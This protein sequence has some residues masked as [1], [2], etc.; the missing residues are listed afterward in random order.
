MTVD[1]VVEGNANTPLGAGAADDK[2]A[3]GAGAGA[4]AG[5]GAGSGAKDWRESFTD[6][7]LR[8]APELG[9]YK[10]LDEFAKGHIAQS[11]LVGRSVQVP[12]PDATD[13]E[14]SDFHAKLPRPEKAEMYE[15]KASTKDAERFLIPERVE[16]FKTLAHEIGLSQRQVSA[17]VKL[18]EEG[19]LEA[20][21]KMAGDFKET[22][23][24][25]K[26]EWGAAYDR[27]MGLAR[28][29]VIEM[30]GKDLMAY[31]DSTGLGNNSALIKAFA[32][33][34]ALLAEDGVISGEVE[35][36][37]GAAQAQEQISKIFSDPKD[38]YWSGDKERVALVA[39]LHQIAYP[40]MGGDVGREQ[41]V[42][43]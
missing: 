19:A 11:S 29:F 17:L 9:K 42:G 41:S 31:L 27:H 43:A 35:G 34:G 6:E 12:K 13:K 33:S 24:G 26:T 1:I 18:Q 14:W 7:G 39:R 23:A 3:A 37:P 30:G 21:G 10:S 28:R 5:E 25:L 15:V 2:G 16:K 8:K 38:G 36:V 32:K 4:G 40:N 22:V 20:Y